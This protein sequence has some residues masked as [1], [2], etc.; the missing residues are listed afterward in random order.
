MHSKAHVQMVHYLG[1]SPLTFYAWEGSG[2][3]GRGCPLLRI[4]DTLPLQVPNTSRSSPSY[5]RWSSC[6]CDVLST[7]P[8][9]GEPMRSRSWN[10]HRSYQ[11]TPE[12]PTKLTFS[13]HN[14]HCL[15]HPH[16]AHVHRYLLG[17]D[18]YAHI[19]NG[20][21]QSTIRTHK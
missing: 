13:I 12:S 14:Y 11:H 16:I 9:I 15:H 18:H 21:K 17:H 2:R 19:D 5:S 1:I 7:C 10:R 8:S 6:T 20:C 4:R 3:P